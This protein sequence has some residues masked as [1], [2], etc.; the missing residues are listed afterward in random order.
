MFLPRLISGIVLLGGIIGLILLGGWPLFIAS[1]IV[2]LMCLYELY[3]CVGIEKKWYTAFG[4]ALVILYYFFA[5]RNVVHICIYALVLIVMT[6]YVIRYPRIKLSPNQFAFWGILY[7]G[8]MST[9]LLS[10]RDISLFHGWLVLICSWGAD[11]AAYC[12][13]RLFGKRHPFPN[14]SPKKS[15]AG[16]IGGICGAMILGL[17]L[18]LIMKRNIFTTLI[19]CAVAAAVSEIGDLAASAIKRQYGVKDYGK[20]IPGHGG[21]LD[22]FD[23]M[24]F[25]GAAIYLLA[26]IIR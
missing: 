9:G 11:T 3:K 14:L 5:K 21:V 23:S 26:L 10:C 16:C 24:L 6:I 18:A 8:I 19:I 2:G 20:L 4:Y 1:L 17:V 13:G 15:V 12:T 25:T 22:R 7:C